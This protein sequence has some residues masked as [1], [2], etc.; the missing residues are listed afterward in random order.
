MI[1]HNVHWGMGTDWLGFS[2]QADVNHE[3][4][5][6]SKIDDKRDNNA[7]HIISI[8]TG[9]GCHGGEG[10][11]SVGNLIHD[12]VSVTHNPFLQ[13]APQATGVKATLSA[14][15]TGDPSQ[16]DGLF[17]VTDPSGRPAGA[18]TIWSF[19][20]LARRNVDL[21]ELAT[22]TCQNTLTDLLLVLKFKPV[23]MTH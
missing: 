2:N 9:T 6:E 1:G 14:F 8:N 10:K 3:I 16:P 7:R 4:Q 21:Q 18:P 11:T 5:I 13:I 22:K 17:M 20:D 19:N 12:P 23:H 15:L